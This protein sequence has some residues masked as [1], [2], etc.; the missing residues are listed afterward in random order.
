MLEEIL[1]NLFKLEIPLSNSPLKALNSYVIRAPEGNLVVDTGWNRANCMDTM[2]AGLRQLGVELRK[3]DFFITHLHPDHIGLV[4]RLATQNARI[5]FNQPDADLVKCNLRWERFINF[6]LANGF[7]GNRLQT[8][9]YSQTGYKYRL[10]GQPDFV[11]LKDGDTISVGD[12]LFNCVATPG[13]SLGHMCLHE[14]NKKIF[15]SGDHIL[16]DITP[17]IS[18]WSDDWDPLAEYMVSLGKVY[19]FDIEL[20]LPG[21][22]SIF[23]THRQ[24]IQELRDH[25]QK[26][27]EE[28]LSILEGGIKSAFEVASQMN[29]DVN[30]VSWDQFPFSQKWFA[31]GE[32]VAHLKYLEGKSMVRMKKQWD[33][34]F[35][36]LSA[37]ST[38]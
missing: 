5:Y 31:M 22:R 12:Y 30:Y 33:K 38:N 1:T 23:G 17:I 29:W 25:H 16:G 24:R 26:R 2:Q 20:V 35:F 11:I 15:I 28:I 37:D 10:R 9:F 14:S 27:I 13:H 34:I 32:A 18:L 36:F 8:L 7:P 3:T 19:E 6:G 4:S 21:H